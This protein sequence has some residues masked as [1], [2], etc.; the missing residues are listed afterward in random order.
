MA[1]SSP[2]LESER[3]KLMP[4]GLELLSSDYVKWMNDP[5]IIAYLETGGDYTLEKLEEFLT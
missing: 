2:Y 3:L 1:S 4:L 5:E